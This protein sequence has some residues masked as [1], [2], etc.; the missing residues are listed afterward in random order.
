MDRE[1]DGSEW[2]S[3]KRQSKEDTLQNDATMTISKRC[4]CPLFE[5]L[6]KPFKITLSISQQYHTRATHE[7]HV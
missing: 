7:L 2:L 6:W 5:A 1:K 3:Q 4:G